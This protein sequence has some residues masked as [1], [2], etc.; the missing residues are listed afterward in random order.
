MQ[1]GVF[2]RSLAISIVNSIISNL[3]HRIKAELHPSLHYNS[4]VVRQITKFPSLDSCKYC[5]EWLTTCGKNVYNN[6]F[7]FGH[8]IDINLIAQLDYLTKCKISSLVSFISQAPKVER[9]RKITGF[10][11][12]LLLLNHLSE[13][14][15]TSEIF[16]RLIRSL[17]VLLIFFFVSFVV[18][19]T[20]YLCLGYHEK[21]KSKVDANYSPE[22][23]TDN[24]IRNS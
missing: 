3:P 5:M 10:P 18:S 13:L 20:N 23:W 14:W 24:R 9:C 17:C 7:G 22:N 12:C 2:Y 8:S 1:I 4:H 21:I 6:S 15:K 16:L 19:F 11:F